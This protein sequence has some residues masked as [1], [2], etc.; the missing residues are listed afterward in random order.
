MNRSAHRPTRPSALLLSALFLS[1]SLSVGLPHV[2]HAQAPKTI[3]NTPADLKGIIGMESGNYDFTNFDKTAS[4]KILL[5]E[6]NKRSQHDLQYFKS[7]VQHVN[8]LFKTLVEQTVY[9]QNGL[10]KMSDRSRLQRP[11]GYQEF[12]DQ[13]NRFEQQSIELRNAIGQFSTITSAFPSQ[14]PVNVDGTPRA[15]PGYGQVNFAQVSTWYNTQLDKITQY[16]ADLPYAILLANKQVH[17]IAEKSGKGLALD[18]PSF[19]YSAEEILKLKKQARE[20]RVLPQDELEEY[21]EP[22]TLKLKQMTQAFIKTYGTSERYRYDQ[23]TEDLMA[24]EIKNYIEY[25]YARSYIRA[26]FGMPI[27]AIGIRYNKSTFNLDVMFSSNTVSFLEEVITDERD[28]IRAEQ[29]YNNLLATMKGR[30]VAVFGKDVNF[31]D[32]INT[33]FTWLKGKNRLA[34]ANKMMFELLY[35]DFKEERL[36]YAGDLPGMKT[37]FTQRYKSSAEVDAYFKPLKAKYEAIVNNDIAEESEDAWSAGTNAMSSG[38]VMSYLSNAVAFLQTQETRL[39]QADE[40]DK[41][42]QQMTLIA[43]KRQDK[44]TRRGADL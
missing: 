4:M 37:M 16:L 25:F 41:Q 24:K 6:I 42:I 23:K 35:N 3:I 17:L 22:Y 2:A 12:L 27:G 40:L 13:V 10:K 21:L 36:M 14:V 8:G 44:R 39:A 32:R 15:I 1:L 11:V 26:V 20:L 7:A 43:K 18:V 31:L 5:D 30:T 9:G 29:D 19:Q 33:A 28:M 34:V 38:A